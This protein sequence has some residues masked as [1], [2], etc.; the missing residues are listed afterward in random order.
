MLGYT[1]ISK[2]LFYLKGGLSN[3]DLVRTSKRGLGNTGNGSTGSLFLREVFPCGFTKV[4][5]FTPLPKTVRVSV[6]T[7]FRVAAG[8]CE[9]I[10][11]RVFAS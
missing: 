3:P 4:F 6:G 5:T 8:I 7:V 9:Q 10:P 2:R 11:K 1:Q